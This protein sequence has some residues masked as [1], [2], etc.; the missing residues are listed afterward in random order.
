MTAQQTSIILSL[1][2]IGLVACGTNPLE[3]KS[4]SSQTLSL[5]VGQQ[6]D[7][8]VGTVGPGSYQMPTISSSA[9]V[10]LGDSIIGP[11]TPAGP[12]QLYR[13]RGVVAGR[14]IVVITHSGMEPTITDTILVR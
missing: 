14:A 13:F 3:I 1:A 6:L 4:D 7:L 2:L 5:E 10:F 11:N 12:R 9:V 8:T